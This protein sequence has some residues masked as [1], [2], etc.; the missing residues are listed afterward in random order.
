MF[1]FLLGVTIGIS[2][3]IVIGATIYRRIYR[4]VTSMLITKITNEAYATGWRDGKSV[5]LRSAFIEEGIGELEDWVNDDQD[6]T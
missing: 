1:L 2:I 5:G 6:Y 4:R 3:G